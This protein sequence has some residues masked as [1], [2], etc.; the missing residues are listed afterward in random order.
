MIGNPEGNV[1]EPAVLMAR[2]EAAVGEESRALQSSGH[3]EALLL[4]EDSCPASFCLS[5]QV[6]FAILEKQ[7]QPLPRRQLPLPKEKK[8]LRLWSLVSLGIV[9]LVS[10]GRSRPF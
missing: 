9:K 8:M 3:G 7:W 4:G 2:F 1:T 6:S 10:V 5:P